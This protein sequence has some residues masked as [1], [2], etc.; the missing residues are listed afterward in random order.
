MQMARTVIDIDEHM[1][2][3]AQRALRT[4][5]KDDTVNTALALAAATD[6]AHRARALEDLSELMSRLDL[7]VL[8]QDEMHNRQAGGE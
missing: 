8:D 6:A 3:W 1:L 5:T 2:A 4:A 7:S